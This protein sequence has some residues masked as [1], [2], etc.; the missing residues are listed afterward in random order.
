MDSR[1]LGQSPYVS[2]DTIMA[3]DYHSSLIF[4][5]SRCKMRTIK[6]LLVITLDSNQLRSIQTNHAFKPQALPTHSTQTPVPS[7]PALD[8]H[9]SA[10]DE[11]HA[12]QYASQQMQAAVRQSRWARSQMSSHPRKF[13]WFRQLREHLH[14]HTPT[15]RW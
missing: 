6:L 14:F 12:Q 2:V 4:K 5:F 15:V 1:T 9:T 3:G 8:P 7:A 13:Q 11:R 10:G